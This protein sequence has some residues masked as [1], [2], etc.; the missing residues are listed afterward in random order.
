MALAPR[1]YRWL[2]SSFRLPD[3][4]CPDFSGVRG[5]RET[6]M[7]LS[8]SIKGFYLSLAVASRQTTNKIQSHEPWHYSCG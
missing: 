1:Y 3:P 6:Y 4:L 7:A 2:F 8:G 5:F